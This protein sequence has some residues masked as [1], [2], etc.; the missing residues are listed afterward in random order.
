MSDT[1]ELK[2][3]R[4][5]DQIIKAIKSGDNKMRP[6]WFFVLQGALVIIAAITTFFL[7]LLAVSFIIFALQQNGGFMAVGFGLMGWGIFF[8]A[9][10]WTVLLLCFA[11]VLILLVLLKRYSFV[12]HQPS[13][14]LLLILVVVIGLGSF[15]IEAIN[16]HRRIEENDIP[17]LQMV[18]QYETAPENYIYRGR[19]VAFLPNGFILSNPAGETS[20]ILIAT[21]TTLNLNLF[22][23]GDFVMIFG[24]PGATATI[25]MYGLQPAYAN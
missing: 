20:T 7:I 23:I 12:Y 25:D 9:L 21:G 17:G 4:K 15:F 3:K 1:Q 18:Y 16:L 14:Y 22:K 24:E 11:L 13:L 2:N 10:P 19:I 5:E 6:H 8:R